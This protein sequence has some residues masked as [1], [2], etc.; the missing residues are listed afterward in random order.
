MNSN[1]LLKE[2][3]AA[4]FQKFPDAQYS[5]QFGQGVVRIPAA[6]L[7]AMFEFLKH[8]AEFP[9]EMLSDVTAVDFLASQFA[10]RPNQT[11]REEA[12]DSPTRFDLVY[13]FYSMSKN[14]RLR[15]ITACGGSQ[16]EVLS[17][18]KWW[19]AAHFLERE[20]WDMFGIKFSAHPNLQRVL[21]YDEFEGHPLRKDYPT[22]DE[23]PR[24]EL[25]NPENPNE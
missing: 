17:S 2:D 24:I 5:E 22:A 15:V 3:L 4:L 9:M 21:L 18:Y 6:E 19:R 16:P 10:E 14:K 12:P 1:W 20:V 23:Q 8:H 13:H 25:R 7:G 11:G